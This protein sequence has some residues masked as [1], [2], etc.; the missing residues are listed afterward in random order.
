VITWNEGEEIPPGY[1]KGSRVRKGLV[2]AGSIMFG[3]AWVPTAVM[4]SFAAPIGILPVFGPFVV[5][6]QTGS[7]EG[8]G[9][10]VTFWLVF[11]GLQQAVGLGLLIGGVSGRETVLLRDDVQTAKTKPWW[12]PKP[13]AFGPRGGGLGF[14]GT[15]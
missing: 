8:G 11:D 1:H 2:I 4:M 3:V 10:V 9:G 5:A 12:L 14:V 13:M 15:M 6:A 7:S